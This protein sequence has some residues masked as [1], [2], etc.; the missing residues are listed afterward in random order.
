MGDGTGIRAAA[1]GGYVGNGLA[2]RCTAS[3][4]LQSPDIVGSTTEPVDHLG[5]TKLNA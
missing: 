1:G 5:L 3:A 2:V 4:A